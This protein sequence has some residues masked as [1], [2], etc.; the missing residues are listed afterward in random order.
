MSI[1]VSETLQQQVN[2]MLAADAHTPVVMMATE[3]RASEGAITRALPSDMAKFTAGEQ[4]QY[5]LSQLPDWGKVTTIV[6]AAG[7]IFETKADFPKGKIAQG[8]YNLMGR[9]GQLHGHLRLDLITDI[10]F[11]S[12]PFRGMDSYYIGFFTTSGECMFKVYLGRDKKRQL[13]PEQI[14]RFKQLQQE[15]CA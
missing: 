1:Q 6:A 10:A 11:V 2:T 4:A 5:I 7:S 8:F 13:F 3:L 15:L 14:E 12:K 9:E